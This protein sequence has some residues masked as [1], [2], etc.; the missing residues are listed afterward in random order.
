MKK[1]YTL[2]VT[3]FIF[4]VLQSLLAQIPKNGLVAYY[5]LDGN[6]VDSSIYKND[7]ISY[8]A[9]SSIDRFGTIGGCLEFD[10]FGSY[11]AI[12]NSNNIQPLQ[13]IT[14]SS[15][16]KSDNNNNEWATILEKRYDLEN[17]PWTSYS[18]SSGG[19]FTPA[20]YT[21][22]FASG[23]STGNAGSAKITKSTSNIQT[24]S[25]INFI[26][27]YDGA[28]IKVFINGVLEGITPMTGNIGYSNSEL[29]IGGNLKTNQY[30]KGLIDDVA[31]YDR[32]LSQTEITNIFTGKSTSINE[33]EAL[34][35]VKEPTVYPNPFQ[36]KIFIVNNSKKVFVEIY[37][38][39][40]GLV[41]SGEE[42]EISTENLSAGN[43]IVKIVSEQNVFTK[44]F[45]KINQ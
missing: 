8:N 36:N 28:N 31:I 22:K 2:T 26:T 27:T 9:V 24:S 38:S 40:G 19:P 32:V 10:G 30:F 3:V 25:W 11:I 1:K 41:Y 29:I 44:K 39:N 42:M 15:W 43:Y 21:N 18:L 34:D 35:I 45:V 13:N 17:D 37:N 23:F 20:P 4:T 14:L 16:V 6:A 12:P 33:K 5:K 7:G